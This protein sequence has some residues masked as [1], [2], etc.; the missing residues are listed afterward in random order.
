MMGETMMYQALLDQEKRIDSLITVI[1]R[2]SQHNAN[3]VLA[4]HEMRLD[5][6][7]AHRRIEELEREAGRREVRYDA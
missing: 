5:L 4:A 7:R 2:L 1:D 6:Y 3:L